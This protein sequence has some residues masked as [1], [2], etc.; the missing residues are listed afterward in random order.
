M[1]TVEEGLIDHLEADANITAI[2]GTRIYIKDVPQEPTY[3]LIVYE[4]QSTER[5]AFGLDGPSGLTIVR[6]SIDCM[7]RSQATAIDLVN[8]VENS[9]DGVTGLLGTVKVQTVYYTDEAD[10]SFVDGDEV[11]RIHTI[12]LTVILQE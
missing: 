2:V 11:Y 3:P 7:A 5:L 4:R 12:D 1:A 6:L 9:L 10:V 8:K